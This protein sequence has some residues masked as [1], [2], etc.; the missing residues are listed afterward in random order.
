M[1]RADRGLLREAIVATAF[2]VHQEGRQMLPKDLMETLREI[3]RDNST[4]ASGREKRTVI[5]RT[6]AEEMSEAMHMFTEG[7]EGQRFNRPGTPWAEAD[8]TSVDLGTFARDGYEVQM[9]VIALLNTIKNIAER[10]QFSDR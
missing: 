5:R 2:M 8:V 4:D 10:D 1:T 9:A 6:R 3:S 7:F